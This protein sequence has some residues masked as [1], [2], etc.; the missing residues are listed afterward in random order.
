VLD[1]VSGGHL[2][3]HLMFSI[4]SE[5]T[6]IVLFW[7]DYLHLLLSF[8]NLSV[9]LLLCFIIADCNQGTFGAECKSSCHCLNKARCDNVKGQCPHGDCD[10]GWKPGT[11][12]QSIFKLF[13]LWNWTLWLI[14]IILNRLEH[15]HKYI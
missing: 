2:C 7:I 8:T 14:N 5:S 9:S 13:L 12:S 11:C 1:K 15:E 6:L 3:W 10:S 4:S